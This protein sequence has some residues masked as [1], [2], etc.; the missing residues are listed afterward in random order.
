MEK[1]STGAP[2]VQRKIKTLTSIADEHNIK[3]DPN[4]VKEKLQKPH[5]GLKVNMVFFVFFF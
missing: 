3:W 5:E 1:L 4:V 2:D